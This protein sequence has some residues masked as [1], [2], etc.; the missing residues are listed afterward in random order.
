MIQRYDPQ[1]RTLDLERERERVME[2][3]QRIDA[4]L[5]WLKELK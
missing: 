2:A 1:W 3:I 4:E 5:E